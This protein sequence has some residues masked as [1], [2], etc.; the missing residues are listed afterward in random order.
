MK[1]W[2]ILSKQLTTMRPLC[3]IKQ[4]SHNRKKSTTFVARRNGWRNHWM[5]CWKAIIRLAKDPKQM[6]T[7]ESTSAR[8]SGTMER[9]RGWH[10]W[11]ARVPNAWILENC[12]KM[13]VNQIL[14]HYFM[15]LDLIQQYYRTKLHQLKRAHARQWSWS[16]SYGAKSWRSPWSS[17][18]RKYCMIAI[19]SLAESCRMNGGQHGFGATVCTSGASQ[20]SFKLT[21]GDDS[22]N[23]LLSQSAFG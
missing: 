13:D 20:G 22:F 6:S 18:Q 10:P 14:P 15:M 1:A 5:H 17:L 12:V 21:M 9:N 2:M 23:T 11:R 16:Y 3:R 19:W 8:S 4:H 7:D